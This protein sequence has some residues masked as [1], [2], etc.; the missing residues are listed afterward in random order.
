MSR[1]IARI[2]TL[3][4]LVALLLA[5]PAAGLSAAAG[6]A[7]NVYTL[8]N[9][10]AGNAVIAYARSASGEL[11]LICMPALHGVVHEA[12]K[13]R[14]PSICTRQVRHAPRAF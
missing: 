9:T 1:T 13:P 12:G 2:L 14:T 7:G 8:T 10:A 11:T 6:D 3:V 4:A 5:G